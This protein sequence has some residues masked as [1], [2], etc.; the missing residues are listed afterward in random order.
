M[1]TEGT[2]LLVSAFRDPDFGVMLSLGA[3][4]T[5]TELID[6][7]ILVPAPLSEAAATAAL[8]RL[9]IVRKAGGLPTGPSALADFVARFAAVA[10]AVP[11]RRF[12]LEV[13]PIKWSPIHVTAV[14]GLLIIEEP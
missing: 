9:R 6:D 14:D 11:W 8:N 3:G 5:M 4:G 1:V 10:A 2:E 12:V 13:N 7:V